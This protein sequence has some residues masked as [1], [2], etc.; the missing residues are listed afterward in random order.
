MMNSSDEPQLCANGCGF[1]G[2][3][4]TRNLC[5][6]CYRNYL[7]NTLLQ[8]I[9]FKPLSENNDHEKKSVIGLNND[10]N[11]A[12]D[13]SLKEV[14]K[15]TVN[16]CNACNKRVGLTGF[17]CRCGGL[18]CGSHRYPEEHCCSFDH[19]GVKREAL[20]KELCSAASDPKASK[21]DYRA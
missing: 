5:S 21:L 12:S 1:F 10:D 8:Q 19:K 3:P 13:S 7:Q 11:N 20:S 2:N 15:K 17:E 9:Q 6:V 16:R 14:K 4:T 18:Y